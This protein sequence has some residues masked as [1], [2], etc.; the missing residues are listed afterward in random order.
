M[1]PQIVSNVSAIEVEKPPKAVQIASGRK[2]L[3]EITGDEDVSNIK[4][5]GQY[6][7]ITTVKEMNSRVNI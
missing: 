1:K 3:V 7:K 4:R 5:P 6:C 2:S